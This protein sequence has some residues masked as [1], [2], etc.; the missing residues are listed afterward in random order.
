MM[1]LPTHHDLHNDAWRPSGAQTSGTHASTTC[2]GLSG[3]AEGTTYAFVPVVKNTFI[4]VSDREASL[5]SPRR[6]SSA[7]PALAVQCEAG[8]AGSPAC[9]ALG[10]A[11]SD[12]STASF[13]DEL[14]SFTEVGFSDES[15]VASITSCNVTGKELFLMDL[16]STSTTRTSL[17]TSRLNSQAKSWVPTCHPTTTTLVAT[18]SALPGQVRRQ[19]GE[20]VAAALAAL[21]T[22]S[23]TEMHEDSRGWSLYGYVKPENS[24]HCVRVLD[25]AKDSLHRA[26][27]QSSNIYLV[28]YKAKPFL[29]TSALGFNVRLALVQDERSACWDLLGT[30]VCSRNHGCRWQHPAWQVH[31]AVQLVPTY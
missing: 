15:D 16:V 12:G 4:D 10:C 30:G 9:A 18:T 5:K 28:G 26:S 21:K 22:C 1:Y 19:F 29:Q 27:E 14:S 6:A 24:P 25:L 20:V 23:N 3:N 11:T 17:R 2:T 13:E 7:P 31:V 8:V